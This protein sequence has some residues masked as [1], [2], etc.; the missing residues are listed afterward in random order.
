M[1]FPSA[2]LLLISAVTTMMMANPVYVPSETET[3]GYKIFRIPG[4]SMFL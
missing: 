3:H 4:W 2:F 1:Q